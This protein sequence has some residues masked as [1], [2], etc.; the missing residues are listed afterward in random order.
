MNFLPAH[1]RKGAVVSGSFIDLKLEVDQEHQLDWETPAYPT[2]PVSEGKRKR[3]LKIIGCALAVMTVIAIILA[4]RYGAPHQW[5]SFANFAKSY[6]MALVAPIAATAIIAAA[7]FARKF[8]KKKEI[9]TLIA[10]S[11]LLGLSL[12]VLHFH[13]PAAF[14]YIQ[15]H[16]QLIA[17]PLVG[18]AIVRLT[19]HLLKQKAEKLADP[20]EGRLRVLIEQTEQKLNRKEIITDE[21]LQKAR[22]AQNLLQNLEMKKIAALDSYKVKAGLLATAGLI[23]LI[24]ISL[25]GWPHVYPSIGNFF[26]H[27]WQKIVTGAVPA[28]A[29]IGVISAARWAFNRG[30]RATEDANA[31]TLKSTQKAQTVLVR[32]AYDDN[33]RMQEQRYRDVINGLLKP[34]VRSLPPTEEDVRIAAGKDL[35]SVKLSQLIAEKCEKREEAALYKRIHDELSS[36]TWPETIIEEGEDIGDLMHSSEKRRI[37]REL[38]RVI[39]DLMSIES[40]SDFEILILAAEKAGITED[41]LLFRLHLGSFNQEMKSRVAADK[42]AEILGQRFEGISDKELE[43]IAF[44]DPEKIENLIAI[45]TEAG[46]TVA[47]ERLQRIQTEASALKDLYLMRMKQSRSKEALDQMADELGQRFE[48][49][50]DDALVKM[51]LA[52]HRKLGL[53]RTIADKRTSPEVLQRLLDV[54]AQ[55]KF[56]A[57]GR[58]RVLEHLSDRALQGDQAYFQIFKLIAT[59]SE[60]RS[61]ALKRGGLDGFTP[62]DL[63][64]LFA[65]ELTPTLDPDNFYWILSQIAPIGQENIDPQSFSHCSIETKFRLAIAARKADLKIEAQEFIKL[66]SKK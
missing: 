37:P 26:K 30:Q 2:D 66:T 47:L 42:M 60:I 64:E 21:E 57:M 29:A 51:I 28:A 54:S 19:H 12:A 43:V 38:Y 18:Y 22:K 16:P 25:L 5:H 24:G 61:L 58:E 6:P 49:I 10:L 33:R 34:A 15:A 44:N 11:A 3:D 65:S 20:H 36:D 56:D 17:A 9:V 63:P 55:A 13:A 53:L 14:K 46:C 1:W 59:H 52:D 48:D 7:V 40:S 45:A 41:A 62:L 27:H 31:R 39:C 32:N 23:A 50:S 8:S 35:S 4:A